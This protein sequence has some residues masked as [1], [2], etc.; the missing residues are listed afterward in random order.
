MI[1]LAFVVRGYGC[2]ISHKIMPYTTS[3][4]LRTVSVIHSLAYKIKSTAKLLITYIQDQ[5]VKGMKI[6]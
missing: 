6:K 4:K 5:Y 3:C 1:S 2:S